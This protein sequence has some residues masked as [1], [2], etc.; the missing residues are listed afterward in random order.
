MLYLLDMEIT[1]Y[2]V[3]F[4]YSFSVRIDNKRQWY[5]S[6]FIIYNI[7]LYHHSYTGYVSKVIFKTVLA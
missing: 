2:R 7:I 3:L 5:E 6:G 4:M 1:R